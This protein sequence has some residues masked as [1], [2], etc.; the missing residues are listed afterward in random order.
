MLGQRGMSRRVARTVF[1]GSAPRVHAARKGLSEPHIRLGMAIPGEPLGN[2]RTALNALADRSTYLY[3]DGERHWYDTHANITRT[4]KDEANKLL[5]DADKVWADVVR[6][7]SVVQG[8]RGQFTAVHA[9]P[10]PA[11]EIPDNDNARLVLIHPRFTHRSARDVPD[12]EALRFAQEALDQYRSGTRQHRNALVFLAPDRKEIDEV[13]EAVREYLG[14]KQVLTQHVQLD[15]TENQRTQARTR[16]EKA[17]ETVSL[18]LGKA[19][20]WVLVP[21]QIPGAKIEWVNFK[22]D[23]QAIDDAAIQV[24]DRLKRQGMLYVQQAP[25]V[26][27]QRIKDALGQEWD[28]DGHIG[29]GRLW[30]LHTKYP[31]MNRLRDRS[32]LDQGVEDVL[33]HITWETDG[34]A[35]ATG[36]DPA[37][38]RY[39]GLVL[40]CRGVSFGQITDSTLLV[41]ADLAVAQEAID[42]AAAAARHQKPADQDEDSDD[43]TGTG[44][45]SGGP[46]VSPRPGSGADPAA[47]RPDPLLRSRP[48]RHRAVQQARH[49]VRLRDPPAPRSHRG[50]RRDHGRDPGDRARWLPRGQGAHPHRKRQHPETASPVRGGVALAGRVGRHALAPA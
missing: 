30:E 47:P 16:M 23:L 8:V 1:M 49:E 41:R 29:V 22:A 10:L 35:L 17:D 13:S 27:Y 6:R 42:L 3:G 24:G 44:Q 9:A 45:S 46:S 37:T 38:G 50:R 31:Y 34:F 18:R 48:A 15:L 28:R 25:A 2:F 36:H 4:A 21:E 32:V 40:P 43:A 39:L 11:S 14:W 12:T 20:R 33:T 19:Y 5:D 7:L 26:L